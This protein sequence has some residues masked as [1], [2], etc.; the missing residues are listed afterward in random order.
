MRAGQSPVL[1]LLVLGRFLFP[2][3]SFTYVHGYGNTV[4]GVHKPRSSTTFCSTCNQGSPTIIVL[5]S[6]PGGAAASTSLQKVLESLSFHSSSVSVVQNRA[7]SNRRQAA[8]MRRTTSII[9]S[10]PRVTRKITTPTPLDEEEEEEEEEE[11]D[12]DED[13]DEEDEEDVGVEEVLNWSQPPSGL[14]FKPLS[15]EPDYQE[16]YYKQVLDHFSF[17]EHGSKTFFQRY[18]I[19]D[20]YWD[21][22]QGPIFFYTGN[23]VDIWECAKR[24]GFI[25]ELAATRYYGKSLPN[26]KFS[27]TIENIGLLS[28]EQALADF[29]MLIKEIKADSQAEKCPVI[30]FGSSYGGLL[31]TYMRI[32]YPDIV[33]GALASSA[34]LYSASGSGDRNQFF[35]DVTAM[36][37][38]SSPD[39]VDAIRESFRE[40]KDLYIVQDYSAISYKMCTCERLESRENI[41][42]L[43]EFLRYALTMIAVMNYPY[44]TDFMGHFPANPVKVA[45]DAVQHNSDP[46]LGLHDLVGIFYNST[47]QV[48]CYSIYQQFSKCSDP[49]G[50]GT[51]IN[52]E[53]WDY[54]SCT[55]MT[56]TFGSNNVTD[57]FPEIR[58]SETVR[59]QYCFS[60]WHVRPRRE[61]LQIEFWGSDL[62]AASNIIFSNG[63]LDP[64]ANGGVRS[65]LSASLIAI[66]IQNSAHQMDLRGSNDADPDSV[67]EA[68]QLEAV[69]IQQWVKA[70]KLESA[71]EKLSG[72]F[73][74]NPHN[75]NL[76][77]P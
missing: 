49:T 66:N 55:E 70:A 47:G 21:K 77:K 41:H 1:S 45:C 68:R 13:E 7:P 56:L 9:T 14:R 62:K 69:I 28:V 63:D 23:E 15:E 17:L 30:V 74:G 73:A 60:K 72:M 2:L 46:I 76:E 16:K 26:G 50:C 54:Q 32:K 3:S 44:S 20:E 29:V 34:P 64:W 22:F 39:C 38:L 33:D 6:P 52:A 11:E 65:N 5:N 37:Q 18:L 53:A 67:K 35:A 36:Y 51:G 27:T 59:E 24:S 75:K 48:S 25:A 42:R 19:T 10:R 4:A 31:S 57:M 8:V 12:E 71:W 43:Y 58:F 40:I 61:W